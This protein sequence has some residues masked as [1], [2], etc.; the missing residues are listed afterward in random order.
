M[1]KFL[2]TEEEQKLYRMFLSQD[3]LKLIADQ[4]G[5][6]TSTVSDLVKRIRPVNQDTIE[7]YNNLNIASYVRMTEQGKLITST[8]RKFIKIPVVRVYNNLK[9]SDKWI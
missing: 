2:I 7:V 3:D 8:K 4:S 6:K 9:D 5:Y 1:D